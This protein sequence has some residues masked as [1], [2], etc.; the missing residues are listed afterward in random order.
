MSDSE[1]GFAVRLA[2]GTAARAVGFAG[3]V[4]HLVAERAY[5]PGRPL[6]FALQAAAETTLALQGKAAGSKLREDGRFD[7]KVKLH[8]VRREDR[9]TLASLRG[10]SAASANLESAVLAP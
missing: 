3:E 7:L 4:M 1:L 6:E 2:D 8:T 5:P 9:T 10:H